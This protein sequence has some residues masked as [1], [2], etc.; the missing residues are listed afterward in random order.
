MRIRIVERKKGKPKYEIP[1][2]YSK[3]EYLH[4]LDTTR[5]FLLGKYDEGDVPNWASDEIIHVDCFLQLGHLA[6]KDR[7]KKVEDI[8]SYLQ[9]RK[10]PEDFF[11]S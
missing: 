2:L 1:E 5:D 11:Y 9:N 3:R 10:D 4:A 7:L 8:I 6:E